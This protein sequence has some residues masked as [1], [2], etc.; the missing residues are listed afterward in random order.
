MNFDNM[1]E[2]HEKLG[3]P[4]VLGIMAVICITLFSAFKRSGWL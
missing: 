1:P 2:L 3:Y 4:V